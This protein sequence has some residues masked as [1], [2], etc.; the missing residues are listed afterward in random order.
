MA[1]K[2]TPCRGKNKTLLLPG[3]RGES[4]PP[5]AR[6]LSLSLSARSNPVKGRQAF[7][8]CL[9]IRSRRKCNCAPVLSVDVQSH[10]E[11][12]NEPALAGPRTSSW[13]PP[14]WGLCCV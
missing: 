5:G 3:L 8:G 11:M 13:V 6:A 4:S 12:S 10:G 7:A 14:F 1:R 2:G 9:S